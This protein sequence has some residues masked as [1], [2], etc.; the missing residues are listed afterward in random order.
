MVPLCTGKRRSAGHF[1]EIP[2]LLYVLEEEKDGGV[3]GTMRL[4]G[5]VPHES[6]DI[7]NTECQN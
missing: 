7:L 2:D 3:M 6:Q 5:K 1:E 4:L